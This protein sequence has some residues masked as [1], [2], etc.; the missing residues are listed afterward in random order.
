MDIIIW[1]K[2]NALPLFNNK[3]LSDGYHRLIAS[4]TKDKVKLL[5]A[6]F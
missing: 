6:V 1:N 3:Y 4:D 5:V 2:T